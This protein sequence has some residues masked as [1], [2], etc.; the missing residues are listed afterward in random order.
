MKRGF[1][2]VEIMII[3]AII[4]LLAAIAIPNFMTARV[5]KNESAAQSA[6]RTIAK[7]ELNYRSTKPSYATLSQLGLAITLGCATE[8]CIK[9]GYSFTLTPT[10][11]TFVVRAIPQAPD[12][13]GVRNFC[14][15]EDGVVRVNAGISATTD[16]AAC[17]AY[18]IS[19]P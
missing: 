18:A 19:A 2:L 11:D 5:Q 17:Q 7:A 6:L 4:A 3:V 12:A 9:S 1:T 14:I 10:A 15:T 16:H 13:T 8:P